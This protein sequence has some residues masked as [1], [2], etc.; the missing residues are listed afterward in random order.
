MRQIGKTDRLLLKAAKAASGGRS[1]IIYFQTHQ[2]AD[3]AFDRLNRM[4]QVDVS[5]VRFSKSNKTIEYPHGGY[6]QFKSTG[7]PLEI[8]PP[9]MLHDEG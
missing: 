4:I 8:A 5:G 9:L 7:D 2:M 6:I 1:V 3:N